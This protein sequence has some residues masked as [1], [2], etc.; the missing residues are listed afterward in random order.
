MYGMFTYIQ[1]I[2]MVHVAK[3]VCMYIYIYTY[4]YTYTIFESYGTRRESGKLPY[5]EE[6]ITAY[7][8]WVEKN[9]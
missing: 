6:H 1:F 4:V 5:L 7:A 9:R 3:Y 2:S 8:L